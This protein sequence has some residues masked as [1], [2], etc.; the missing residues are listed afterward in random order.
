MQEEQELPNIQGAKKGDSKVQGTSEKET[1]APIQV[2]NKKNKLFSNSNLKPEN[3]NMELEKSNPK[4]EVK[5]YKVYLRDH[6]VCKLCKRKFNDDYSIS[7]HER[8]SQLHK[9]F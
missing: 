7:L 2:Q 1:L 8:F 9:V 4:P 5:S 6:P 3:P